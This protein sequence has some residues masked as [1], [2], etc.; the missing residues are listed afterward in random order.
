MKKIFIGLLFLLLIVF[1]FVVKFE[2]FV[3]FILV[4]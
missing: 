2:K 1:V 4:G 3:I